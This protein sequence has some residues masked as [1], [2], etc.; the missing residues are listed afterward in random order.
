MTPPRRAIPPAGGA[1]G[2][3]LRVLAAVLDRRRS[4]DEALPPAVAGLEPRDRAFARLLAATVLRRLGQLDDALLACLDRGLPQQTELLHLLRLGAAQILVI[5]TPVHAAVS[6]TVDLCAG[7]LAR[8]R[9]LVNAVLRRLVRD[10]ARIIGRQ[11]V[12]RLCTPEWAWHRWVHAY[13]EPV[14]RAIARQHLAEPAIDLTVPAQGERWARALGGTLLPTGTLRVPTG[15]RIEEWPGF[16]EGAWWVQD[17]A[18]ALPA[19]L[20]GAQPG[21]AVLDL[22]A[23]PGG[24]TAQLA[25]LGATVTAVDRAGGRLARVA[26]N[27]DRLKLKARLVEQDVAAFRPAQPVARILLDAPCSATGTARRH[28]DVLHLK[29][30]ADIGA[31]TLVQPQLLAHAMGLLQVGGVLVYCVCSMEPEEGPEVVAGQL[32]RGGCRI[33]PIR[34]D[35]VPGLAEA[36]TPD[37][38]LRTL[39]HHWSEQGGM[40]GFFA[41]RLVRT[42]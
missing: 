16:E 39:P 11:D 17:A 1:R 40:D 15:G 42:E 13:G 27:L 32:A 24:K 41:A 3:A 30:A 29:T 10:G 34:P 18:A 26:A 8:Y 22:C 19:R 25:A 7:P 14:A 4:L 6:A 12:E 2:A 28:P 5:E 35:E 31:L 23:A 9:G 36:I 37:G 38:T 33:D 21:E 20:L